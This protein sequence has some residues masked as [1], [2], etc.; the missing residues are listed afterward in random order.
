MNVTDA[1]RTP[2]HKS[3]EYQ[4]ARI[5]AE[6][7]SLNDAAPKILRGLCEGLDWDYAGLWQVDEQAQLLRPV[8]QW[9]RPDDAAL[10]EFVQATNTMSF[11][12]GAG[13]PGRVW[14]QRDAAWIQDVRVDSRF[15]RAPA[16]RKAG[17]CSAFAFPLLSSGQVV[18]VLEA[19][20]RECVLP[21][22]DV[23]ELGHSIGT[24]VGLFMLRQESLRERSRLAALVHDSGD[25]ILAKDLNGIILDWNPAAERLYGYTREDIIGSRVTLLFPPEKLDQFRSI[26]DRIRR[27]ESIQHE[28]TIRVRKDGTRVEVSVTISPIRDAAGNIVGASTIARDITAQRA[29]EQERQRATNILNGVVSG[30]TDAIYVKDLNGRYVM[31]NQAGAAVIGRP[32]DEILGKTVFELFDAETA[33][34]LDQDDRNVV[35]H[36]AAETVEN[37]IATPYS[38]RVYQ[39]VKA[40]YRNGDGQI[41]GII[42]VSRDV[43]ELREAQAELARQAALLDLSPDAIIVRALDGNIFFWN[44]GAT[45][46]YGWTPHE[47]LGKNTHELFQTR[48]PVSQQHQEQELLTKGRWEGELTHTTRAGMPILVSSR[49]VVQRNDKAQVTA[50]LEIN[51]DVTQRKRA[52]TALAESEERYRFIVE[53]TSDGI[54]RIELTA[55][56]PLSLPQ[57]EQIDWYYRHAVISQCNFG[58]ARMYGYNSAEEVI[59]LPLR[60]VMP[61][62]NP[63]NLE[64]SQRFLRSGY[65]LVDAESRE[66]D[67]NGREVVFL[68]NMVGIIKDGKLVGEWGTNR[69]I[70]ERK[71][72][73]RANALLIQAASILN[74]SLD[75]EA[76]LKNIAELAIPDLADWCAVHVLADDGSIHRLAFAHRNPEVQARVNARPQHYALDA[77][78][79]HLAPHVLRTGIPEFQ[80][81]VPDS[82]LQE[83]ARDQ[84][85][86]QTLRGLNM[87]AYLCIP[88]LARDHTL[89]TVTFGMSE[90][91]R[92][93]SGADI[94][95]AQE[96][97]RRA[98]L[99]ADNARLFQESQAAQTRLKLVAEASSELIESLDYKARMERLTHVV[100][101]R[102]ADWCTI[103]LVGPDGSIEL[104]ALAHSNSERASIIREWV[105]KHPLDRSAARGTPNVIRTAQ[106]EWVAE[107]DKYPHTP[108]DSQNQLEYWKRLQV[109]SYMIVPLVARAKVLGA[110]TF[111]HSESGRRYTHPDL[112]IG[113]EIARRAA[114]ALDNAILFEQ[115]QRSRRA[116]EANAIRIAAL[117]RIAAELAAALEP[118][119]VARIALEQAM[120]A[121]GARAGSVSALN[122]DGETLEIIHAI[123]YAPH[124][125][126]TWRTF[127]IHTAA[128]LAH[129]VL[130]RESIY[131]QGREHFD[132]QYPDIR[133]RQT[134]ILGKAW[135][136]VPL[137]L[138]GRVLGVL[139][140]TFSEE[141]KFNAEDKAFLNALAQQSSQAMERARLYQAEHRARANA[142]QT[143]AQVSALQRVTAALGMALTSEQVGQVVLEQGI[144]PLGAAS[145]AFLILSKDK[146]T[147]EMVSSTGYSP[148]TMAAWQN[149]PANSNTPLAQ[150]LASGEMI[151]LESLEQA[152]Q[153][154]PH[155][156]LGKTGNH[157]WLVLPLAVKNSILGG[158]WLSFVEERALD[159]GERAYALGIAQQCAQALERVQL[160]QAEQKAREAAEENAARVAALQQVTAALAATLTRQEVGQVVLEQS[161]SAF[162]AQG[163]VLAQV[164]ED[165]EHIEVLSSIG[166]PEGH[167]QARHQTSIGAT[168]SALADVVRSGELVTIESRDLLQAR[169]PSRTGAA[170][171][172]SAWM[173]VPLEIKG[174]M[175][176]GL[177]LA[178]G[179]PRTFSEADRELAF[180][181]ARQC[182]QALERARLYE[183]ELQARRAAEL[184]AH[185]S[186]WLTE[187]SHLLSGS[188]EYE[189]TL[190]GLAALV[191]SELSDW[192]TIDMAKGDGTA[193]QL[194]LSHR[195]PD[196]LKWAQD[197]GAEIRQYFEPNWDAPR[198]LP[199]VLRTGKPEIYY[200]IPD[201]LLEQVAKNQVQLDILKSIGYSSVM[202]VPLNV[203]GKTLGA[204]TMVNT[205]NKKHFTDDDLEFAELFAGRAAAAIEN[206]RLYRQ[207]Q[208]ANEEL[209]K[210]NLELEQRVRQ[211]TFEL[212]EAY[213][214]IRKE[215]EER[216]RAEQTTR[217]L[218]RISN[219][220]NST[221][222]VQTSLDI[223]IQEAIQVMDG[224]SGFAGLR[225]LEGMQIQKYFTGGASIPLEYTWKKGKGMPGWVLEHAAPYL[226]ND[227]PND[228]VMLHDLPFNDNVQTAICTPVLDPRGQVVGFFEIRDKTDGSPFTEADVDFLQALSPI[229]SIALENARAYQKISE[230]ET[231]VQGSYAQLRALAA[232]LQTIREEER[233]DIARELHDELGQSL[234]ALKMDLAALLGRLPQRS[235]QLRERAQ[236]MSEQIDDTIKVVRR[237]SSQLRPG[238]LDDLGLGPSIEWYAQEFQNRTN[239]VVETQV[240]LEEFDL[241][242]AHATALFRIFQETLTNV[243]RHANATHVKAQLTVEEHMLTMQ[244]ADN[245]Q[246]FDLEQVR[247]KRSLGLLGMRERA[248]NVQ[249]TL[250]IHGAPGQGTTIVVTVPLDSGRAE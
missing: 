37:L 152:V 217:A 35:E 164:S 145:G 246:G 128:P 187:A 19:F 211:R 26:M 166:Y 173:I 27:G 138:E 230:A 58:L 242:Y 101:P 33:R 105:E 176:G 231:A 175:L 41:T 161:L 48:F 109:Q 210:F 10:A 207:V 185:R 66:I 54:W 201:S 228:P 88:L 91:G 25:A 236:S 97:V 11:E 193:E 110:I 120:D 142:E 68:N 219:R 71:Q 121:L 16:A 34:Q 139:G 238:M 4:V 21:N 60:E 159:R 50:I 7:V 196:K 190:K 162:G 107:V 233:T 76:T 43:T 47:V 160:Y 6:A 61:L 143:A 122:P 148:E 31:M 62:D 245:G 198:G 95:L 134:Q 24:Q 56:M 81:Q 102:F 29:L 113:E 77:D 137:L 30:T 156:P 83:A 202:I 205:D 28:D 44:R 149:I 240:P 96:I 40:P 74:A 132:E 98:G 51:E 180:A 212:S 90:S 111:V 235:K 119:Q 234:T 116:V 125:V 194:V 170:P 73:E 89:G 20:T 229:A 75:F 131:L 181:M 3:T 144:A 146:Q 223:L 189:A 247:G 87:S 165:G 241:S 59:G 195:D 52:E 153:R 1:Q 222:D 17:L 45:L 209:H 42:G 99:A 106:P 18:G 72:S 63:V 92:K 250:E 237:M 140:L 208:T 147:I 108:D 213:S 133:Q 204:I 227:A 215:V 154:Y 129:A 174:R 123:G 136:S 114:I 188:L 244:I 22:P 94:D 249:G 32:P 67:K 64:L 192:C 184:A 216:K 167:I 65:R 155:L 127:S 191:V 183:S 85:H 197:F 14:A 168:D 171:I 36:G 124:V 221:L 80:N 200:D 100:V 169:F 15:P 13:L 135:A 39:S 177:T 8:A 104:A 2:H 179:E 178:F 157:A 84:S 93:Y 9:R 46:L 248:E 38:R 182:A 78:A 130:R 158:L 23:I 203:Q 243:A 79:K 103:N 57:D 206:A 5:L 117:Q 12:Q 239:I 112:A 53:N 224:T 163:G 199:N 55:P 70:T 69:D 225:V 220:L 115:E 82:F 232:R 49:Q 186:E 226:T 214:E 118:D 141:R 126:E 86:L 218:L 151:M 172:F 150:A